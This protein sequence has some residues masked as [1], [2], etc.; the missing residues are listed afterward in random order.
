VSLV[1]TMVSI[2]SWLVSRRALLKAIFM[3]SVLCSASAAGDGVLGP[4]A[5]MDAVDAKEAF[6]MKVFEMVL[7]ALC[8]VYALSILYGYRTNS[9]IAS[10]AVEVLNPLLEPQFARVGVEIDGEAKGL[11]KD[12]AAEMWYYATGRLH[13]TGLTIQLKLR[14][15]MDIFAMI[16]G[17]WETVPLDRCVFTLPLTDDF[18]MEPFS[19]L[20]VK[21]KELKALR[22]SAGMR[23]AAV[24]S[25]ESLAGV[26]AESVEGLQGSWTILTDHADV[27]QRVL[28]ANLF[29]QVASMSRALQFLHITDTGASWDPQAARATRLVRL[30]FDLPASPRVEDMEKVMRPMVAIAMALVDEAATIKLSAAAR[31][32]AVD[33]RRRIQAEEQKTRM[34]RRQEEL[35]VE[36]VAKKRE[37]DERIM[38]LS[39][40]EQAKIEEKRRKKELMKRMKK[41]SK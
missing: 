3:L 1:V 21:R 22:E 24:R 36:R 14:K 13:T 18:P 4:A 31:S 37:E 41:V 19:L 34:K 10:A 30:E 17:L 25:V 16:V 5:V 7:A 9:A 20:L 26:V 29:A 8:V 33:L 15:R 2:P 40:S 39:G 12:G 38:K 23:G 32:K 28:P 6:V 35:E 11:Y 27:L